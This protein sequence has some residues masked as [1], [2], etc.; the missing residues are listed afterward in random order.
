MCICV[1]ICVHKHACVFVCVKKASHT[2]ICTHSATSLQS[3]I[4]Y[5]AYIRTPYTYM[6]MHTYIH[7]LVC[8]CVITY[9]YMY[10][11]TH[12]YIHTYTYLTYVCITHTRISTYIN[13]HVCNYTYIHTYTFVHIHMYTQILAYIQKGDGLWT[14]IMC[15]SDGPGLMLDCLGKCRACAAQCY[16]GKNLDLLWSKR[17]MYGHT[18]VCW[19]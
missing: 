1:Y 18:K 17:H 4:Q 10:V 11:Y 13:I 19:W 8:M 2:Y 12:M 6:Y 5:D 9:I 15:A 16:W 14:C 3:E 7:T